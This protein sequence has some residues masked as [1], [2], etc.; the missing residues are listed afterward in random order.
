MQYRFLTASLLFVTASMLAAQTQ[1]SFELKRDSRSPYN[2]QVIAQGDFN[3]DGKPDL[4][5]GGNSISV[6]VGNGDGT[7]QTPVIAGVLPLAYDQVIEL[8]VADVNHDGILDLVAIGV[9][10]TVNIFLGDGA[11]KFPTS[12][13]LGT[14]A[15]PESATIGDF[16]GDGLPDL[17]VG[18][19][20][21]GIELFI[22]QGG[23]KFVYEKTIQLGS[24]QDP[25]IVRVRAGDIDLNG[26]TDLAVL[27]AF[28]A[29]VLW[30]NGDTAFRVAQ[31]GTYDATADLNIG[32]LNQD[33]KVDILVSFNCGGAAPY[34]AK[35]PYYPCMGVDAFYGQA[36]QST[37]HRTVVHD[38][39]VSAFKPWAVDVNGD[40]I[41]DLVSGTR[42]QDGREGGLFI[43]LGHPDGSFEQTPLRYISTSN[44]SDNVIPGDF[45]RDGMMDFVDDSGELYINGANRA[46]CAT[47][48]AGPTVTV[49]GPVDH[50]FAKAPFTLQAS[51]FDKTPIASLQLYVDGKEIFSKRVSTFSLTQSLSSGRHVLVT[52]A[53]DTNGLTFRSDRTIT[54]FDGSPGAACPVASGSATLCFPEGMTG[55]SP[56]HVLG[57]AWPT[58][59]NGSSSV[60]TAAQ[61]YIDNQ[62][63]LNDRGCGGGAGYCQGGS[64]SLDTYQYLSAGS[65]SLV[66]KVYDASGTSFT[67]SKQITID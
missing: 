19:I 28:G 26:T 55:H 39:G 58:E 45:N 23:K 14:A 37:T 11:G 33:G 62:L 56:F 16:N 30:G 52:K 67:T 10:G 2:E 32:D 13:L 48:Q 53:W 47:S 17:A 35:N 59:P 41:A 63:V 34:P 20:R 57:N 3:G 65:H 46:G 40:G 29:Y 22:N 1:P 5:L 49:C 21:G 66:F 61:L 50:T 54:V 42:D 25:Q 27:T 36:N 15:F 60:P 12:L 43:W 31:L 18:D 44:G 6:Q 38:D 8:T 51:A 24:R 4:V 7:F 9:Q 64:S